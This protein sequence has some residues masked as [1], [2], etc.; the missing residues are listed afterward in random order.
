MPGE[1]LLVIDD[2][3]T[4]LKVVE[5]TLTR[6]GYR[7]DTAA[8]GVA[9]LSLVRAARTVPGTP[10]AGRPHPAHLRRRRRRPRQAQ[11][12]AIS[13]IWRRVCSPGATY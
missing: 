1:H 7:V 10:C 6:A 8:D 2:S 3:P 12:V 9:G 5:S 13:Q 11:R 4:L